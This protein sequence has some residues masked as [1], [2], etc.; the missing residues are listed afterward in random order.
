RQKELDESLRRLNKFIQEN[1]TKKQQA[2]LKAKEEKLQAT[3]LDESIRSLLL[4]TKNLRKRLSMLKVEVK[5]MGRFGQFLESVLEVSEEFN[6]VEDVLKRFETLKTTNQDLASRSNTAVQRNEAAKKELAQVRMSRDDDVMQLN[7]RIAQVLHT[8]DDETTDLSPEESLDKQLSSA[9]D[10]L[11]GVSACY[12]GIDNLYSRVR[13]VTTVPRPLETET[14]AKLSRIAFFIQDLEAI[15]QEV[16]R[17][18][19]RDRDKERERERETQS[20]T[21]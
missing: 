13:S 1:N 15:L 21:K 14:E 10:A 5:H 2:E 18:E 9:Q 4:Y 19:Q 7:T 16:R 17:T 6:T 3:Q 8:L 20:Q 11:V 12:L